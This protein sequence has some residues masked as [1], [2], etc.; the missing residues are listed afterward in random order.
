MF[1]IKGTLIG[2][3]RIDLFVFGKIIIELKAVDS[4]V[5]SHRT[6]GRLPQSHWL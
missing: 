3:G 2:E 6:N 5:P 1:A 4:L